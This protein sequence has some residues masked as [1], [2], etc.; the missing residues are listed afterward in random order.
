MTDADQKSADQTAE[1]AIPASTAES[2]P[3]PRRVLVILLGAIGDVVRAL[4][5]L[6]RIRRGWPNAHIAWAIEP[7]SSPIIEGHH[8]LD[9]LIIYD[10]RHAPWSFV[11]FL[12]SVRR[13][14][15]DLVIDLQRHLK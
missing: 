9:E 11:P 4:P 3:A 12:Q 8:W 2:G 15:F 13:R 1:S 14:R 7:K 5:L 10:R 6:G